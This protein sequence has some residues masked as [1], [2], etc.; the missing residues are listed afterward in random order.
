MADTVDDVIVYSTTWCGFCKTEKQ[1]LD[2]LGVS[3]VEKD[4]EA[5][6]EAFEELMAKNGGQGQ[7]VPQTDIGGQ[8]VMG[9][10]RPKLQSLLK[11][12]GLLKD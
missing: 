12:K 9:F 8:I 6:K 7:G 3:Y 2:K 1:W 5:D 10:D 4:I 11:E